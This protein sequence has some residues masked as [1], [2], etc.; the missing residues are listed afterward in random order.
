MKIDYN[1]ATPSWHDSHLYGPAPRWRRRMLVNIVK[2][3]NVK[4]CLDVGCAQ[5]FL[6]MQLEQLGIK[7]SGCDV[8]V[9]VIQDN[10]KMYPTM[11]FFTMDLCASLTDD[12][13][14][15]EQYDLVTCSEVLEHLED[16]ETA[17]SNLC[18]LSEKYVLIT[19]PSGKRYP[20]D[21]SVGHLRHY[22]P[23]M[24]IE[25]LQKNGFVPIR[26]MKRGF[27]FHSLYKNLINIRGGS[28]IAERYSSNRY[29]PF[30]KFV[31]T[32]V[33]LLFYLNIF[34]CGKQL[35]LLAQR[36]RRKENI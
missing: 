11:Q 18:R 15:E 19:V 32:C 3:L 30:E 9:P 4:S 31:S 27:P 13:S 34:P 6:M 7:M 35:I 22:S 21:E 14:V 12:S 23:D 5:P 16:Y 17:I 25:P 20:I 24:L 1:K 2:N 26:V 8:S 10:A 36:E 29:G 28:G 33:Y